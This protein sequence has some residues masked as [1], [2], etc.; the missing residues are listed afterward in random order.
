VTT[1]LLVTSNGAGMGHLSRQLS[2]ALAAGHEDRAA[3]FSL[4]LGLPQVLGQGVAGEYCPSY[5]RDMVP[6]YYWNRY[7]RTRLVAL[8]REIGAEAILFD[9]VAPYRGLLSTR[10][11]LPDTAFLW[12]RRGMWIEGKGEAFLRKSAWFDTVLEPGDLGAAE[13][14]GPTVG[15]S[16][17][18]RIPPVSMLEV[19]PRLSR[20]ESAEVLGLDP[21]RP[22]I[23]VTLG[24]GRLGDASAPGRVVL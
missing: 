22:T 19:I 11:H 20:R 6:R 23:L 16:D 24:T 2:L 17:A 4:S 15:R 14:R 9:G 21:D 1:A 7:L 18:V 13:D 8:S 3:L 5:E 12:M 10:Q